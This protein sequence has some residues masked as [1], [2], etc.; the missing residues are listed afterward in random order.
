[1]LNRDLFLKKQIKNKDFF[2]S[3]CKPFNPEVLNFIEDFSRILKKQKTTYKNLNLLYLADWCSKKNIQ[4][5]KKK[6]FIPRFKIGRG[7]VFHISPSNVPTNFI[8]S[9]LF[10]ILSGN[11]NIIKIPSNNFIEKEIILKNIKI[12]FKIK[13]YKKIKN[14]NF[15]IQYDK[16]QNGQLTKNL[17]S[18]CDARLI[19]GG[20]NTVNQ[21]KKYW[22]PE[23]A[24]DLTFP[25]RY[26]FCIINSKKFDSLNSQ[27]IKKLVKNFFY[28]SYLMDQFSCNSPHFVFWIGELD[29]NK[30]RKFWKN[31][32][33]FAKKRYLLNEKNSI[34]KFTNIV[35]NIFEE[36]NLKK[37]QMLH[38]NL[39]VVEVDNDLKKIE[40]IR[41]FYGTFFQKTLKKI[42]NLRE[43]ISKKCQTVTYFGFKKKD[44]ENFL[45]KNNLFG[46]DRI[47]PVGNGMDIDTI[48]DGYDIINSL[49]REIDIK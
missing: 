34:T 16:N 18:V 29:S 10:G 47:V 14:S 25:D 13:K 41:G 42:E 40:N 32:N 4:S 43:H 49:S 39:Y 9:F 33:E 45:I 20:D 48:W 8:Y 1:M 17:S 11:S 23:R 22:I 31:L 37:I 38:S 7:L 28:D 19:W 36:K 44:I 26:S 12:L 15:F 46:I 21:I 3:V 27:N 30:K 5:I 24:I 35:E 6:H 2:I